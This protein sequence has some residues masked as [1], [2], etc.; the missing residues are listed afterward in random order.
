[1]IARRQRRPRFEDGS[2]TALIVSVGGFLGIP[3]PTLDTTK[4]ALKSHVA[5]CA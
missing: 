5:I 4:D 2:V 3:Y 1:L